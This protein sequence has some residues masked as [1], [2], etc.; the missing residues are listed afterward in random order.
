MHRDH[1]S[2]SCIETWVL[3]QVKREIVHTANHETTHWYPWLFVLWKA[4]GALG[5]VSSV[6]SIGFHD[7]WAMC[8]CLEAAML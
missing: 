3:D 7:R 2:G 8:M 5:V 6:H 1:A 4:C